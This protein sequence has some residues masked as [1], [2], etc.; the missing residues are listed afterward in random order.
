[1][2]IETDRTYNLPAGMIV[3]NVTDMYGSPSVHTIMVA[4]VPDVNAAVAQILIDS[5]TA[6]QTIV[7]RMVAAGFIAPPEV[8]AP[9]VA[10]S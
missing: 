4:G 9:S 3:V 10:G 7:Q 5:D 2:A 1:M 6:A 8:N